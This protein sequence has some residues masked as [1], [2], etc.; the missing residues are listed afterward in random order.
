MVKILISQKELKSIYS[1][2]KKRHDS[3][4]MSF[5]NTGILIKDPKSVYSPHSIGLLG[6]HAWGKHIG[7]SVDRKIY[8]VRDDGED[9][10][11]T[12]VK[13]ITYFGKGEPELKIKKEEFHSKKPSLYV[14]ARVDKKKLNTVELLGTISREDFESKKKEKQYRSDNPINYVVPLSDMTKVSNKNFFSS[15]DS[16][17]G[18][19]PPGVRLPE[20]QIE[21]YHYESLGLPKETS[22]YDFLRALCLKGAKDNGIE[23]LKNKKAYYD[24]VKSELKILKE[25][26][27]IDYILLNWD[28]LNYCH[29]NDI[30]TGPG[31]GSAAGSLVL[32]LINVTKIDPIKYDLFFERFVSKSRAKKIEDGGVTY[33]DGSLLADVDNDISYEH[34]HKV[35]KYIEGKYPGR[36]AKILTLNTLSSKLCIRECGKIVGGYPESDINAVTALIPKH[37][38]KVASINDAIE[39]SEKLKEWGGENE[40]I[41]S[42]AKKLEGLNKNSGVH[43]SGIA[44]SRDKIDSICPLQST[45]EGASVTAYDMNWVAELMVKFDIL[46]L[47]TL[48]VVYDACSDLE[49]SPEDIPVDSK[50]P[51]IPLSDLEHGHGLFQIEAHTNFNVCK[52]VKPKTLEELSAV[53]AIARPGALDFVDQYKEYAETGEFQSQHELFDEVLSY[54]GG[55]PLYQEQLM[56]M[57]VK[58]GFTLDEAEQL[59]RIVGKKKIKQ[60]PAWRAKISEKISEN[61]LPVEAGDVLWRVAE[62][63]AN[64]SFNKSHSLAYATLSAWTV[65]LKFK[66]P[67]QFFL[68][69]LKM[70]KFE[71]SPQA[72]VSKISQELSHFGIKLLPPSILKSGMDFSAEGDNIRYGLSSIKGISDKSLNALRKF[73]GGETSTKFDLFL[74]AKDAGLNIGV[75]SALIQAGA[76]SDDP[77]EDRSKLVLEAQLFNI[78]TDRE[79]RNF[80]AISELENIDLFAIFKRVTESNFT[81]VG[82][83][84]RPLIKESRYNT[85]KKKYD[86]YKKIY[87]KNSRSQKFANWYFE[88]QLLGFSYSSQLSHVFDHEKSKPMN[89]LHFKSLEPRER[90][91]YIF[92][93]TF[94]KKEKSRNGNLYIKLELEDEFGTIDAILCDSAREKKCTNYL[95]NNPVPK[96]DSII[97]IYGEKTRDG[98]AIFVNNMKIVDEMIYMNL[99]DLGA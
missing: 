70:T 99:R 41:I 18:C 96:E 68:S 45:N 47:R 90:S 49:I 54:T 75:L 86:P 55:I 72:E 64:Y 24:R 78:L 84:N 91:K 61:N 62:D 34:R 95:E 97:T 71:P 74:A 35:I 26:G 17:D 83:D 23:K 77:G 79:K 37:F 67:Q 85:L 82:D 11:G 32:Y 1:L 76:L 31:R 21:N 6:E 56:K 38:G 46:G 20:I 66:H 98:D 60:M 93:V 81:T 7:E 22:N 92:T 50:E 52:K 15:F 51:Y 16:Y 5:R 14:L 3:K 19:I 9:F 88:R 53:I 42:I 73:R 25:L 27:F 89:S 4:D 87:Y 10:A 43:P 58:I 33:L 2:A 59:R 48:S 63:S 13:T 39:E 30:A 69:L 12:E 57:S 29:E 8:K 94:S 80:I 65:Y 36:T 44:I 28:I 40:K